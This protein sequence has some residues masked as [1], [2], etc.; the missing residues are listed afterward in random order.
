[1][2][3]LHGHHAKE[4][5]AVHAHFPKAISQAQLLSTLVEFSEHHEFNHHHVLFATSCCPDEIN[6]DLDDAFSKYFGRGFNMGGLSGL[7]FVGKT[8]F[9]A[10]MHHVSDHGHMV[11]IAA[12]HVG[13]DEHGVIGK[14]HRKG[15]K[16][17]S[18]ACGAAIA[19]FNYCKSHPELVAGVAAGD[20]V[21]YPGFNDPLDQQQNYI[22]K[23]VASKYD[24]IAATPEPQFELAKVLA[25]KVYED[26]RAIIPKDLHFPLIIVNGIQINVMGEYDGDYFDPHHVILIKHGGVEEDL[27]EEYLTHTHKHDKDTRKHFTFQRKAEAEHKA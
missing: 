20:P 21:A 1:L 9:G 4:R 26:I 15:M 17:E 16:E 25:E 2:K 11:I 6:R 3:G 8:G 12:S 19:A 14:I 24:R 5:E 27:L 23:Y 7:P 10:F 18:S 13:V 22:Q